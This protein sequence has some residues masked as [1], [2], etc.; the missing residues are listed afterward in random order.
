MHEFD[1]AGETLGA[2][3]YSA[4]WHFVAKDH[5]GG[6]EDQVHGLVALIGLEH[7][8]VHALLNKRVLESQVLL[9]IQ[10]SEVKAVL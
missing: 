3:R 4:F 10:S 1:F 5:T 9:V 2:E 6:C 7:G 8:I